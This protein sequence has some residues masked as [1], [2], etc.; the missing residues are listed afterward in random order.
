[1]DG[2]VGWIPSTQVAVDGE[3]PPAPILVAMTVTPTPETPGGVSQRAVIANTDGSGVVL[4]NSPNAA[5]RTPHGLM[6]GMGVT[7]LQR[8]GADWVQ[9]R[10][11][12]GQTGGIPAQYV[13]PAG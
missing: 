11:D 5:D 3:A 13:T 9:V 1:L 7:V 2:V 4:R 6:D 10:A 8:S 12:N